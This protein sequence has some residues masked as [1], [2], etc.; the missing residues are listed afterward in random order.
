MKHGLGIHFWKDGHKYFGQWSE[1]EMSGYGIYIHSDGVFY[2]G[3]YENN[4]KQGYGCYYWSETRRYVGY[5]NKGK[6]HG[7]GTYND[8]AKQ[9]CIF[10]LWEYGDC[11]R[12]FSSSEVEKIK[13]GS[14]DIS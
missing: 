4:L 5:W 7:F 1:G 6:Q 2:Y 11:L 13:N 3:K 9:E 14:F 12:K 10:G 8:L